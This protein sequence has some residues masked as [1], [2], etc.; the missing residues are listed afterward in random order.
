[1]AED[2]WEWERLGESIDFGEVLLELLE[3]QGWRIHRQVGFAGARLLLVATRPDVD[4]SISGEGPDVA[5][6]ALS[7]FNGISSQPSLMRAAA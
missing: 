5:G 6:A 1:M 4:H 3:R 2:T 7:L